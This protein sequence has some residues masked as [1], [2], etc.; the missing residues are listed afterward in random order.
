MGLLD[1]VKEAVTGDSGDSEPLEEQFTEE[2]EEEDPIEEQVEE[3]PVAQNTQEVESWDS[4]YQFSE[5]MLEVDGFASM[6][7]FTEKYM[8]YKVQ[9]SPLFRDRINEGVQTLEAVTTAQQQMQE[10]QGGSQDLEEMADQLESASKA[11]DAADKISG[12]EDQ[13]VSDAL[14]L[15]RD[16]VKIGGEQIVNNGSGGGVD[17]SVTET[18][19][20]I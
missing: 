20:E 12:K 17:S 18:D 6:M 7:D 4:A 14:N 3:D 13:M 5:E 10:I 2:I 1:N 8:F 19:R 11:I 15:G 9:R 16:L